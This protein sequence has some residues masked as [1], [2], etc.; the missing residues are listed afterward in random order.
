MLAET[1]KPADNQAIPVLW[2]LRA[3]PLLS[4]GRVAE[5]EGLLLE[6]KVAAQA[7][8]AKAILWQINVDLGRLY[9]TQGCQVDAEQYF[10]L[11]SDLVEEL[12][13]KIPRGP[14]RD[15][16]V[17]RATAEFPGSRLTTEN[18]RTTKRE[19]GG[20]TSREKDIAVRIVDGKS[21]LAIA[22]ELVIS[23]RTVES[24][25]SNILSKL[26]F[27]SRSQIAAWAVEHGLTHKP[28]AK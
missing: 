24:H 21:N 14:L 16:F 20:L 27:G 6:A 8:G 17:K 1:A 15:N 23:E 4:L 19:L 11:A 5:A 18:A 12:D 2:K 7:V 28:D 22:D 9:L 3:Q 10:M 26:S 25:V 13:A